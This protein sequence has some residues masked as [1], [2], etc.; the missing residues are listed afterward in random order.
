MPCQRCLHRRDIVGWTERHSIHGLLQLAGFR[1]RPWVVLTASFALW[2]VVQIDSRVALSAYPGPNRVW[3]FNPFGWQALFFL[4]AWLGWGGA[5]GPLPWLDRRWLFRLAAGFALVAFVIR[6]SWTLHG[7]YYP[8]PALASGKLLWP[9]LS[10]EDLGL[11]RFANKVVLQ[12]GRTVLEYN[13]L[14]MLKRK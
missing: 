14:R 1:V 13:P 4:G 5:R 9:F 6:F 8:I 12:D 7:L 2:L 11:V 3:A 10:K